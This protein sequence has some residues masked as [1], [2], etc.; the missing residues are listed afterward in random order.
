VLPPIPVALVDDDALFR[1]VLADDLGDHGFAVRAFADAESCLLAAARGL[2]ASLFLLDWSLS[3]MSGLELLAGLRASGVQAP[4]VFLTGSS[5]DRYERAALDAGAAGFIDKAS[6][7]EH[8][9]DR[10]RRLLGSQATR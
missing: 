6:S 8:L 9:A 5:A 2:P 7:I 4:I 3:T 1:E 10:L